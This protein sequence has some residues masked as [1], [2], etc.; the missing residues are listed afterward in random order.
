MMFSIRLVAQTQADD[1]VN[2]KKYWF[3]HYRLLNDFM[4]KGDKPGESQ[5]MG[6]RAL[7]NPANQ[8]AK[9]GDGT[10]CLA[11][12]IS[13]LATEYKLLRDNNQPT[14]TTIQEL[15]YALRAFNRLD[16]NAE[17]NTYACY[18][19]KTLNGFF[20][21]DDVPDNFL[22]DHPNLAH[23]L[24]ST[25]QVSIV[26]SDFD[27]H[28]Q[29][30]TNRDNEMSQDQVMHLMGAFALVR[31]CLYPGG[32][33]Y[34][35]EAG[36]PQPLN[37]IGQNT[38]IYD[39]AYFITNRIISYIK[40]A[41]W[42]IPIPNST[43][44]VARGPNAFYIA[45]G[46]A[47]AANY[48]KFGNSS[49]LIYLPVVHR[50]P[51]SYLN[52]SYQD[53][54]SETSCVTPL[55][56][57]WMDAGKQSLYFIPDDYK[58][59]IIATIGDSWYTHALPVTVSS[60]VDIYQYAQIDWQHP[61]QFIEDIIHTVVQSI[62]LPVPITMAD[63][64]SKVQNIPPYNYFHFPLLFQALHGNNTFNY[65]PQTTYTNLLN[66]A[67]PC[68]PYN[69]GP[70]NSSTYEWS[71]DSRV[72]DAENRGHD[73]G[74]FRG[75]FNGLDYML[76]YNLYHMAAGTSVPTVNYMDR[77]ITIP[78]PTTDNPSFG[79]TSN[80]AN[81]I[82]FNT[83]SASNTISTNTDV[84]YRAGNEITLLPGFTAE[85]GS[86]FHAY[87]EPITCNEYSDP[88]NRSSGNVGDDYTGQTTFVTYPEVNGSFEFNN[89]SMSSN[90][91]QNT[92]QVAP[93]KTPNV[94]GPSPTVSGILVY[95][96]PNSGT[97]Q[98]MI[99]HNN[100]SIGVKELKVYDMMNREVW[101]TGA[102]ANAVFNVDI[103]M[104]S[105]GIYYIRSVNESGE[106]EMKKIIKQ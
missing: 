44:Y 24:T 3:Y 30:G 83:I 86:N 66:S 59:D 15:Y 63:I 55:P 102:S 98:I 57:P 10:L 85:A 32:I 70:N 79:T 4:A 28:W 77:V 11:Q 37:D 69:Y 35:N 106:I 74:V 52:P 39:E 13:V 7:N 105:R 100:Q 56:L 38:D 34:K 61:F 45:Y 49:N 6:Q 48:I 93:I 1:L 42:N 16:Y 97:F 53:A 60:P 89:N 84:T 82:A 14:D 54:I 99:T 72:Y 58:R 18:E 33:S 76:Y 103:S 87:I 23:G 88:N 62:E 64:A 78:F 80:P 40:N 90:D 92:N 9:W 101:S 75:E 71:A 31:K 95:P 46:L 43:F 5:P 17:R 36:V 65:I 104:Y 96:N 41:N 29:D 68:G 25:R 26:E 51:N 47:E 94:S 50:Y 73:P 19:P 12:Y 27:A 22:I 67:P 91:P 21:R 20:M 81:L 2:M 8:I